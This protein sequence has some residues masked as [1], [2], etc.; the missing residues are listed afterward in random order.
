MSESD[1][2]ALRLILEHVVSQYHDHNAAH[3]KLALPLV[4]GIQGPQ[5]SGKTFLS[6][7]LRDRLSSLLKPLVAV[8]VSIDDLYLPHHGLKAVAEANF[9]NPLLQGRGQPG[10]H[11]IDLGI[12]LLSALHHINESD[13]NPHVVNI[14]SFDKSLYNG[15]GDRAPEDTWTS[16]QAPLDIIILEGWFVGF[17]PCATHVL[18]GL[19]ASPTTS[20]DGAFDLQKFC[21]EKNIVEISD[22]LVEYRKLWKSIQTFIQV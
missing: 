20:L 21:T 9:D 15:E 17:E 22:K 12:D 2:P 5:G 13:R 18:S 10:T 14:P 7:L 6:S 8:V 4:V 3:S 11:D 16:V 1:P 19:Y